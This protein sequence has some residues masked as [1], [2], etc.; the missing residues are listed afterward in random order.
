MSQHCLFQILFIGNNVDD[1][2]QQ[3]I[4][5]FCF[6]FLLSRLNMIVKLWLILYV[7]KRD[8]EVVRNKNR[9]VL[10]NFLK[11]FINI[12]EVKC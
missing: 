3:T 10:D 5:I 12:E 6:Y 2:V 4:V 11:I 8:G 9:L 1:G 7:T